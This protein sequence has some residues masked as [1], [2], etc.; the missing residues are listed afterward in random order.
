[1]APKY[2]W[3]T[4]RYMTAKEYIQILSDLDMNIAQAARYLGVGERTSHRYKRAETPIPEAHV[5]L[6]RALREFKVK[7]E[8]PPW[9][10]DRLVRKA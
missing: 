7:P 6:L 1:V 9:V 3:Q 10:S 5:L 8:V 4:D 2:N